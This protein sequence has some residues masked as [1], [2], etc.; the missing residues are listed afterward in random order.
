MFPQIQNFLGKNLV[1][2]IMTIYCGI[3]Y[4]YIY[5]VKGFKSFNYIL[6][7]II[8][9]LISFF[10]V[11]WLG[12]AIALIFPAI[13]TTREKKEKVLNFE[14][15][16]L[17]SFVEVACPECGSK[18]IEYKTSDFKEQ[19]KMYFLGI[20]SYIIG[21]FVV[22]ITSSF[23]NYVLGLALAG[24]GTLLII[25]LVFICISDMCIISKFNARCDKCF[26]FFDIRKFNNNN[27]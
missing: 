25:V 17:G 16:E 14:E 21:K 1:N 19:I 10:G 2:I 24:I 5:K 11:T 20:G 6:L 15:D 4:H 22:N 13:L 18:L 12:G 23:L 27:L 26:T 9:V 3:I 8:A 7:G